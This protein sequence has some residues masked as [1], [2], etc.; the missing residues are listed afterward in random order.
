M[1]YL[2]HCPRCKIYELYN[3]GELTYKGLKHP[4]LKY[5]SY[6]RVTICPDCMRRKPCSTTSNAAKPA[7]G[8]S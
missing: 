7:T 1:P 8:T 2:Y 3:N 5:L 6:Q 4:N